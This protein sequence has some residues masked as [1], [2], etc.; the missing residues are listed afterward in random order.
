[1]VPPSR[2]VVA[3]L[4]ALL[5]TT[6]ASADVM[7]R[8]MVAEPHLLRGA[9]AS[10][11]IVLANTDAVG[12]DCLVTGVD[13]TQD[14]TGMPVPDAK[15]TGRGCASWLSF[16]PQS[17]VL[18]A[19]GRQVV[20]CTVKAPA[21]AVGAYYA[22]ATFLLTPRVPGG[23]TGRTVRR[24]LNPVLMVVVGGGGTRL[25]AELGLD[26]VELASSTDTPWRA[27][28]TVR[29]A[30]NIHAKVHLQ[31]TLTT[32]TGALIENV[33]PPVGKG[34]VLAGCSRAFEVVGTTRLADGRYSFRT[35]VQVEG[36]SRPM[37]QLTPL[38]IA[39]GQAVRVEEAT[40]A[41]QGVPFTLQPSSVSLEM[42]P[43]GRQTRT[44]SL[45]NLTPTEIRLRPVA[46]GWSQAPSGEYL[47]ELNPQ[48][49]RA[50]P[51]Q[52]SVRPAEITIPAKGRQNVAI[53]AAMPEGAAGEYYAAVA[54]AP[55]GKE[56]PRDPYLLLLSSALLTLRTP[57]KPAPQ[58]V[59]EEATCRLNTETGENEITISIR[60]TGPWACGLSGA[61]QIVKGSE[62]IDRLTFGSAT[63]S[64]CA[65]SVRTVKLPWTRLLP[66]GGYHAVV[67]VVYA[68]GKEARKDVEFS[69]GPRADSGGSRTAARL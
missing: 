2:L 69:V 40:G 32:D 60:N 4:F 48:S 19:G 41:A 18:E 23:P 31:C 50:V 36:S 51:A 8:P 52:V 63:E 47:V 33:T 21:D 3:V 53:T 15:R 14:A 11:E 24:A 59:V 25:A 46:L 43:R 68:E 7:L 12:Y 30:G 44:C 62:T 39:R 42:A 56:L 37:V 57:G 9:S 22:F 58:A 16:N 26:S 45:I 61:V 28:V 1:M 55:S 29:N 64:I 17:F 38:G 67:T 35:V 54:F 49:P 20:K 5:L 27:R 34:N 65:G 10:V 6:T 13:V 66:P